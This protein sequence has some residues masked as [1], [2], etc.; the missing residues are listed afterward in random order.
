MT[1]SKIT[2][3]SKAKPRPQPYPLNVS[4][5]YASL[6]RLCLPDK[7]QAQQDYIDHLLARITL[8]RLETQIQLAT[9]STLPG[10]NGDDSLVKLHTIIAGLLDG[11]RLEVLRTWDRVRGESFNKRMGVI[12]DLWAGYGCVVRAKERHEGHASVMN[13]NVNGA[14]EDGNKSG[15]HEQAQE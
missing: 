14:F 11:L 4:D 6:A 10:N 12:E 7:L 15:E 5:F 2:N 8:D 1:T 9:C 13:T 3:T